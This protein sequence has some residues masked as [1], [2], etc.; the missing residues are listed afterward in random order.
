MPHKLLKNLP[1]VPWTSK[2]V[3]SLPLTPSTESSIETGNKH[4]HQT[5]PNTPFTAT[6]QNGC[7]SQKDH[8][9]KQFCCLKQY[10]WLTILFFMQLFWTKKHKVIITYPLIY[11][12]EVFHSK[13]SLLKRMLGKTIRLPFGFRPEVLGGAKGVGFREATLSGSWQFVTS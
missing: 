9:K 3:M 12:P 4:L 10:K 6:D 13:T 11:T 7:F 5:Y 2:Q 8:S 1:I